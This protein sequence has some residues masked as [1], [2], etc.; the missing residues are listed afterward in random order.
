MT[1]AYPRKTNGMSA[2]D[3]MRQVV[4]DR[5]IH[6]ITLNR[7]RYN[8]QRSCKDLTD[9]IERLNGK[10][11]ELIRDLSHHIADEARHAMWL[12]DLLVDLG[13]DIDTPP[14][15][16]YIDEFERL[17]DQDSFTTEQQREDGIISALA[18][19]NVTE[20][21]GCEYFSAHIQ[22]LKEAPQTEENIKIR[23]TIEKIFPEE[24]GHVRWGNRWLAQI[25]QKSFTNKHKVENAKR[26]YA[27]IEQAA[28][29]AGMDI[30]AGAELRR[31]NNL[32]EISNTLPLWER[33]QYLMERLPQTLLS[34]DLQKTRINI[35]QRAWK[36]DPQAFV[37]KFVPMFLNGLN[38]QE[39][40]RDKATV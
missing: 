22:A 31:L 37:E 28:Y 1:V 34:P 10:P 23:E 2:R 3:I 30:M 19:I 36:R 38:R 39:K 16:S 4:R 15:M 17:L 24:A 18:A 13:A 8:E 32:L 21:R 9:L 14:G 11:K 7:Y 26:K 25:A 35:A 33:P 40:T 12:T 29:E 27:A 6:L 5:E 20:K